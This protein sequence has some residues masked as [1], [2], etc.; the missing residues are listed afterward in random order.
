MKIEDGTWTACQLTGDLLMVVFNAP[1][2]ESALHLIEAV[3]KNVRGEKNPIS[4]K[5]K[6]K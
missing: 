2:K 1:S 5:E 4:M 3:Q 6:F